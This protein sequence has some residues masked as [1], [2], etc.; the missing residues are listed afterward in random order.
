M[1]GLTDFRQTIKD[2]AADIEGVW[3]AG[4]PQAVILHGVGS[5]LVTPDTIHP[6]QQESALWTKAVR[7]YRCFVGG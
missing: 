2:V 7:L 6:G 5:D 3:T 1:G 4:G